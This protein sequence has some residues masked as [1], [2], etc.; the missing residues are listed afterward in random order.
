M[1]RIERRLAQPKWLLVA[2]PALRVRGVNLAIVTFAFAVAVDHM[3][4]AN[5]S[6]NGGYKGAP[7]K[8]PRSQPNSMA[9]SRCSGMAA[10]LMATNTPAARLE[11]R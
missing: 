3:I 9:S 11:W 6:V 10:Q 1:I 8:A 5:N 4:F 2:V 7:V